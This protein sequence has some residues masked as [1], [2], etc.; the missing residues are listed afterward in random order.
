MRSTLYT[1][2]KY[3]GPHKEAMTAIMTSWFNQMKDGICQARQIAPDK[4]QALVD[5]GPYLGKEAVAA[6]LVDAVA[7]RDE[8]YGDVKS[9]AGDGA[10]LLYLD[11]YLTAPGVR[12]IVG[13]RWRWCSA[14]AT[15]PAARAITIPSRQPEYGLGYGGGRDSSGGGRQGA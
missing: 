9:K 10:E 14:S 2:T 6:K 15:S 7:Y 12:T 11:K 13:R 5:A 4:F 1:E 3:T 8:V